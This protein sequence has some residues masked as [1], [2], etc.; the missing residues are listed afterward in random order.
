MTKLNHATVVTVVIVV[1][2]MTVVTVVTKNNFFP[3]KLFH[4]KVFTKI[5]SA[6]KKIIANKN[7]QQ[8]LVSEW[9]SEWEKS[10][11]LSTKKI[12]QPFKK[13]WGNEWVNEKI[14]EPLHTK[15]HATHQQNSTYQHKKIVQ[16]LCQKKSCNLQ[17]IARIA[18]NCPESWLVVTVLM[19]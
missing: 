13:N 16:P 4:Q 9:V 6:K 7:S 3:Q 12:I 11:N 8:K 17:N 14:T 15:N 18:K 5:F 19:W 1:T 2:V 10:H